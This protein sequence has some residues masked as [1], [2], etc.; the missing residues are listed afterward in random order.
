LKA[1]PFAAERR[2][3]AAMVFRCGVAELFGAVR[4]GERLHRTQA[5]ACAEAQ[6]STE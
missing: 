2:G 3:W 4:G 6:M 5:A 1:L